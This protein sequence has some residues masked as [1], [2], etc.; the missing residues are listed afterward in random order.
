[1]KD[2]LK[3]IFA[4]L[5]KNRS[6]NHSLQERFYKSVI[7]P[8]SGTTEKI[9]SLLYHIANTQSQPKID[10]LAS[11]YKS[12]FQETSCM[13]SMRKFI[14]KINPDRPLNY[15]SLYNGLKNQNGW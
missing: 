8:Y 6:F 12:I 13:T 10:S 7:L 4:F 14:N 1:M 15:D 5:T 11:F 9:V 3:N 2:K